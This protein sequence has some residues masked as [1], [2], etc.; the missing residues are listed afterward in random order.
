MP[1]FLRKDISSKATILLWE[2]IESETELLNSVTLHPSDREKFQ[3]FSHENKKREFLALRC[4]LKEYFRENPPVFYTA[5]G[6]PFL[7]NGY[8]ISFSH[9][10]H[11]AGIIVSRNHE[12]GIDLELHRE[13][14]LRIAHKFMRQEE[15]ASIRNETRIPHLTFYWGA[16]EVM[17]KITGDR[18]HNFIKELCV[19]PFSFSPCS[20]SCGSIRNGNSKKE[21]DLFFENIGNLYITYGWQKPEKDSALVHH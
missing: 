1:L 7:K 15:E 10:R 18:R 9:S 14:I 4:C 6:K 12:V 16:K 2:I 21:V 3:K 13:G 20:N 17:V 19:K 5:E 11:F 8:K